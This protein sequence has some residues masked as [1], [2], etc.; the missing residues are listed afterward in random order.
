MIFTAIPFT[1]THSPNPIRIALAGMLCLLLLLPPPGVFAAPPVDPGPQ[2]EHDGGHVDLVF[3]WSRKC[4]HC[5][6]AVPFVDALAR[7]YPWLSV[8]SLEVSQSRENVARYTD[9]A[10]SLGFEARSVPAF[11]VCGQMLTGFDSAD[12]LGLQLRTLVLT[13]HESAHAAQPAGNTELALPLLGKFDSHAMSLPL[14]TLV[15]AGLDS[16]NPCAFFVLLFLLS[17][18]VHARSRAR[19]L[20]IGSTFVTISG[21]VY[22]MFMAAWLN[23]FLLLGGMPVVTALAGA[24][25]MLIGL[26]NTRDYF[27]VGR[28]ATLAI[29]EAAKPALFQRSRDLLKADSLP[30]M[31]VG[32]ATLAVAANSYE[33]LCTA[34]FPMVYTRML[35]LNG[36]GGWQYYAWLALY[37]LIYVVPLLII[38]LLFALT[39]GSHKLSEQQ[40]RFLKLLSGLM[41]LGLGVVMLL[42]PDWLLSGFWFGLVLLITAI[43]TAALVHWLYHRA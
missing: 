18:M 16:F 31:L 10:A 26:L 6:K 29:P 25:A 3:F 39:L 7:D 8:E 12:G 35:T 14:F 34:G 20:V 37:N 4:P 30:T 32:A 13:C 23:L 1:D 17:L 24:L 38:V 28:K 41:M 9:M 43:T 5:L 36:Q 33:L 15:I 22:F 2:V 19:M 11:F 27:R 21:L 42:A 40:G